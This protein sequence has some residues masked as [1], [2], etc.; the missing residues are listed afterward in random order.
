MTSRQIAVVSEL[1]GRVPGAHGGP[2]HFGD[3]AAI[4]VP[5]TKLA[6]PDYGDLSHRKCL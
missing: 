1:T 3:G 6:H 4:G 2:I 5:D